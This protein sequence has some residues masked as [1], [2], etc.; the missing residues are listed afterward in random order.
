[1]VSAA[2]KAGRKISTYAKGFLVPLSFPPELNAGR[3]G[4]IERRVGQLQEKRMGRYVKPR[5]EST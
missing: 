2:G 5:V 4:T 1:M 3:E